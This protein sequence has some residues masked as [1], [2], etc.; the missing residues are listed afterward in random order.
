MRAGNK[1]DE[2]GEDVEKNRSH[3]VRGHLRQVTQA[4]YCDDVDH[5]EAEEAQDSRLFVCFASAQKKLVLALRFS[6]V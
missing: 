3:P 5:G 4:G 1:K 2:S 6:E